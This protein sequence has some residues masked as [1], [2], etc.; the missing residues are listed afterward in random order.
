MLGG[1]QIFHIPINFQLHKRIWFSFWV[2]TK[3][4]YQKN[5]SNA[6]PSNLICMDL[7]IIRHPQLVFINNLYQK[8]PT[9]FNQF[10]YIEVYSFSIKK[11]ILKLES[12][13]RMHFFNFKNHIKIRIEIKNASFQ[14]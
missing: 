7:R 10:F 5:S 6:I 12:K 1:Y 4:R 3:V 11:T 14:F 8:N 13:S 2:D 9:F